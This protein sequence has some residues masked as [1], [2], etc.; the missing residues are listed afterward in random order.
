MTD[1]AAKHREVRSGDDGFCIPCNAW[2]V[3]GHDCP[4]AKVEQVD[5]AAK[6]YRGAV[7]K[8]ILTAKE[9]ARTDH[10]LVARDT[11]ILAELTVQLALDLETLDKTV[12]ALMVEFSIEMQRG[13]GWGK[14]S[15]AIR[16]RLHDK[17]HSILKGE[18]LEKP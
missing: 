18:E 9:V 6:A 8:V 16:Q 7:E 3:G 4:Y 5:S 2:Y 17:A 15:E 13:I 12:L 14:P 10:Q 1:S 11:V